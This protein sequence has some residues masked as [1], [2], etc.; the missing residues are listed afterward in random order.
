MSYTKT[1]IIYSIKEILPSYGE[2]QVKINHNLKNATL[3]IYYDE[4]ST[5]NILK[6]NF[7]NVV[8]FNV[9]CFPGPNILCVDYNNEHLGNLVELEIS[10]LRDKWQSHFNGIYNLK[11]YNILL[12]ESNQK[13]DIICENCRMS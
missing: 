7:E 6:L 1:R 5:E 9:E 12:L 11:H 8:F 10:S 13:I 3:E 4:N 2:N